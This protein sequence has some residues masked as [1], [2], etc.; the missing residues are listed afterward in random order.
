MSGGGYFHSGDNINAVVAD[1]GSYASK[2]GF[3]GED[4]P[5]A[6]FRSVRV[7]VMTT[8]GLFLGFVVVLGSIRI[9]ML[10]L[11]LMLLLKD[12]DDDD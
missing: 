12:D 6:Y 11:I 7:F 9:L 8:T 4:F 10:I 3:A 2:I 1:I 5:K